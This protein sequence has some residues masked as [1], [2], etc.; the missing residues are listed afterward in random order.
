MHSGVEIRHLDKVD[1]APLASI[2]TL[3][4]QGHIGG[5]PGT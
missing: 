2:P 1:S 5:L 3:A 4:R